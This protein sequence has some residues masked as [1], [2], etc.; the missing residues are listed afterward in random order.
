METHRLL[1]EVVK[2]DLC[3]GCG[4]CTFFDDSLSMALD[5]NGFFKPY[6]NKNASIQETNVEKAL[7]ICPF[8]PKIENENQLSTQF[9]NSGNF[10]SSIGRYKGLYAGYSKKHRLE[11]SSG[12]I[13]TYILEELIQ[14]GYVDHVI[15]VRNGKDNFYEYAISKDIYQLQQSSKTKYHP[16]QLGDILPMIEKTPGS[17]AITGVACFIKSIRLAQKENVILRDKIKFCLGIICG[18]LKSKNYTNFLASSAGVSDSYDHPF[19]RVKNHSSSASDYSFQCKDSG[20]GKISTI[21]MKTL[22]DMWGTGLFKSNACDF[23][24]DISTELADISVGDAWMEPYIKDGKGNSVVITR[25]SLAQK[26]I[27]NGINTNE[28]N[29]DVISIDKFI[30]S[31]QGSINHRQK[32]INFRIAR[33]KLDLKKRNYEGEL[34]ILEKLIQIQRR[35]VRL[36]SHKEWNRTKN[37]EIFFK[38]MAKSLWLLRLLTRINHR[39]RKKKK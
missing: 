37:S 33:E 25:S 39:L 14:K 9:L 4:I 27:Q 35:K 38:Q 10:N 20:T 15:S 34:T 18:G 29:L 21:Q 13:A 24:D 32:A 23:C 3:V 19:Y 8:S 26:L 17:F 7:K 12:G 6:L 22:G 2:K 1:D 30:S 5:E 31:Q 16:V 11:S 28:L 36:K